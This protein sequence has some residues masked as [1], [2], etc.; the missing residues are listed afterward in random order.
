MEKIKFQV[1]KCYRHNGGEEISIVGS[2]STTLYGNVLVAES[3]KTCDLKPVGC[4]YCAAENWKEISKVD[5]MKN[6][7]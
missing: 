5:W 2:V 4:D 1:G 3:N 6:F 7:S